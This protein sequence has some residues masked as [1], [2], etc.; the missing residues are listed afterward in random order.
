MCRQL[1]ETV[2][3]WKR[4]RY[5]DEWRF[6]LIPLMLEWFSPEARTSYIGDMV[7]TC[8][9]M[10]KLPQTLLIHPGAPSHG[11]YRNLYPLY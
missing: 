5:C 10:P 2:N 1:E 4:Y 9:S 3:I 11:K 7:V 8:S 6:V